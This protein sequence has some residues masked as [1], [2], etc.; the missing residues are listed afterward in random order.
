M[1][2]TYQIETFKVSLRVS[3]STT[4]KANSS[5]SAARILQQIYSKLDAD[6]EHFS[7]LAL[8][9]KKKP[10]G[11]KVLFTGSETN[12]HVDLRTVFVAGFRLAALTLVLCHNH[13]SGDPSPS[14]EDLIL[15]SELARIGVFLRLPVVDHIILG[16]YSGVYYSFSDRGMMDGAR[17][18]DQIGRGLRFSD[19]K[20]LCEVASVLR[21]QDTAARRAI[22]EAARKVRAEAE[23]RAKQQPAAAVL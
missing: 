5:E 10:R 12:S 20:V 2:T 16:G 6:Q 17:A 11:F 22:R 21:L 4:Q 3:E 13:P 19:Y 1:K 7:I 14:P 18:E 9:N 8:D 15:T 23:A